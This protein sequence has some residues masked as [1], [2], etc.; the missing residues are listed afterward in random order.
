MVV[1]KLAKPVSLNER[2]IAE[3]TTVLKKSRRKSCLFN[4]FVVKSLFKTSVVNIASI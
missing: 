2:V 3:T 1:M 4:T